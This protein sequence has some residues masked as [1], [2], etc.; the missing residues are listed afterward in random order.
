MILAYNRKRAG[1]PRPY[2][3]IFLFFSEIKPDSYSKNTNLKKECDRWVGA[4]SQ[5]HSL[6]H[7]DIYKPAPT[8]GR[9][10]MPE[11]SSEG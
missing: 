10:L 4:G 8:S 3:W 11:I 9:I 7:N 6:I 2:R 1:K 5:I